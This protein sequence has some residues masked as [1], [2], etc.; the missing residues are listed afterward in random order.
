MK[1]I[2]FLFFLSALCL[3]SIQAGAD[4]IFFTNGDRVTGE[5]LK[6]TASF[7]E[8]NSPFMGKVSVETGKI[9]KI[10]TAET[11]AA[12]EA[13]KAESAKPKL[14]SGKVTA[15]YN[16]QSG[17]TQ[18]SELMSGFAVKR[19]EEKE[20]EFD[21]AAHF[22]YGSQDKKMSAQRYDGL[23]RYAYSFLESRKAY[24][25]FKTEGDHD[26]F[27]NIEKR[28][29]PSTG[30]GYWF[31]DGEDWKLMFETGVGVTFTDY[32]D[33]TESETELVLIPRLYLERQLVGK[34][35]VT[36]ELTAYPSLTNSGEYRLKNEA[37]LKN[38][39]T[40]KLDLKVSAINEYN[41]RPGAD[42]K[43]H[44]M[45]LTSGLEYRF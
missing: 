3:F 25:F 14:W 19:K 18:S 10:I 17:N 20:N 34:L 12:E 22:Y 11:L 1:Q 42:V 31:A 16:R 33:E 32:R 23:I 5:V 40:D 21:V 37:A 43:K 6:Q 24:H 28:F 41:S 39:I 7:T 26:R 8:I 44:D 2:S 9:E 4:Q 35:R 38:P 15:G 27:A 30:L 13:K 45:R 29:T 36:E